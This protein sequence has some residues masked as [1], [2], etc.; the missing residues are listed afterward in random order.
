MQLLFECDMATLKR[1]FQIWIPRYI[2]SIE[3]KNYSENTIEAAT[4]PISPSMTV[5]RRRTPRF[6]RA[7]E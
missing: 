7:L 6:L 4:K 3:T 2:S 1:T 5:T